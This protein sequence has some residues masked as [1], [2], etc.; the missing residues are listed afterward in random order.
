MEVPTFE[1]F[2]RIRVHEQHINQ[3]LETGITPCHVNHTSPSGITGPFQRITYNQKLAK[4]LGIAQKVIGLVCLTLNSV[5]IETDVFPSLVCY[6]IWGGL[7]VGLL[8]FVILYLSFVYKPIFPCLLITH[9][10]TRSSNSSGWM[11]G[12]MDRWI[13]VVVVLVLVLF[14]FT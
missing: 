8:C 3:A 5:L 6:G 14:T 1:E 4:S 10:N 13:I 2:N 7:L 12:W 11:D 9:I